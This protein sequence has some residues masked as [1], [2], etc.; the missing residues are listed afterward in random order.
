MAEIDL[1]YKIITLGLL[2][3]AGEA[4]SNSRIIEFFEETSLANYFTVQETLFELEEDGQVTMLEESHKKRFRITDAGKETLRLF[5]DRLS[6]EVLEDISS[7]LKEHDITIRTENALSASYDRETGGG[8]VC[9]VKMGDENRTLLELTLHA[10][11]E[12]QAETICTNW[13]ARYD[14]VYAAVMDVLV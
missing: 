9:H 11:S 3:R 4:L 2:S 7:Y 1:T 13:R 10:M 6:G 8:F 14:D 12:A 5:S